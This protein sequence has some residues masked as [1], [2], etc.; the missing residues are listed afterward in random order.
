V[1]VPLEAD[2]EHVVHFA[3]VPVGIGP[4]AGNAGHVRVFAF[5]GY[6]EAQESLALV[7]KKVVNQS[8]VGG[9]KTVVFKSVTGSFI[10]GREVKQKGERLGNISFEVL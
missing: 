5:E 4:D 7:R 10:D 3:F 9:G 6:L 1:G 2:A 8:K